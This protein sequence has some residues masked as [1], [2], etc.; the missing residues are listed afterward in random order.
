MK[1]RALHIGSQK[2]AGG[3]IHNAKQN[4]QLPD[5]TPANSAH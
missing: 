4:F 5:E 1:L 2:L 3:K